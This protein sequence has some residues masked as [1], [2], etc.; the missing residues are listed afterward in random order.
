MVAGNV[1]H[2]SRHAHPATAEQADDAVEGIACV[3]AE[4][5]GSGTGAGFC[6]STSGLVPKKIFNSS[7][8]VRLLA[9][10][11]ILV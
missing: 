5:H 3:A 2:Q 6:S 11:L 1:L 8:I 10:F 7:S 4:E 9:F